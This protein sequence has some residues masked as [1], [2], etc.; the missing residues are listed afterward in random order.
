VAVDATNNLYVTEV[1]DNRVLKLEA[2]SP[3]PTLLPFIDLKYPDGVAADTAGN[4]YVADPG[5]NRVLKLA[6]G[7]TILHRID[8]WLRSS[9]CRPPSRRGRPTPRGRRGG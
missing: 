8:T 1:Q 2:G 5:N 6:A 7:S 3:T 4:L 9:R